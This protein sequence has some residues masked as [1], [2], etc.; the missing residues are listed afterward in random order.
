MKVFWD[1][2][3]YFVWYFEANR[4]KSVD[5]RVFPYQ[6]AHPSSRIF[7]NSDGWARASRV[8][9][10]STLSEAPPDV[11]SGAVSGPFDPDPTRPSPWERR[12]L[13]RTTSASREC[14]RNFHRELAEIL[15]RATLVPRAKCPK[16]AGKRT[17]QASS[18]GVAGKRISCSGARAR[19]HLEA[20]RARRRRVADLEAVCARCAHG[21]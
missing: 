19:A 16:A 7:N 12:V 15:G 10:S 6:R 3:W 17:H 4:R 2:I 1:I 11:R 8:S 21:P 9:K 5:R 20:E 14:P 18:L 13:R